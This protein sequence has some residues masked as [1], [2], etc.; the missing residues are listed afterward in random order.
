MPKALK[1]DRDGKLAISEAEV[2]FSIGQMLP[3]YQMIR[4]NASDLT[5]A[6]H[7]AHIEGTLDYVCIYRWLSLMSLSPHIQS[8]PLVFFL[9]AKRR[10]AHT[11]KKRLAK[12]QAT[13]A[14]LKSLGHVVIHIPENH[15]DPIGYFR[16]RA[17]EE[18]II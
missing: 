17:Q 5:R 7:P 16:A 14:E 4:T 18:G 8:H 12:Q 13:A 2:I 3:H 1:L 9:E 10:R 15:P 6:G 11:D